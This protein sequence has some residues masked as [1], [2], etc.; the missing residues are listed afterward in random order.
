M[1]RLSEIR[2]LIVELESIAQNLEDHMYLSESR[3]ELEN[4][5]GTI[6][7]ILEK[8]P[9]DPVFHPEASWDS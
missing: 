6:K 5:S 8:W 7:T 1:S 3:D 9:E 4:Q 2:D